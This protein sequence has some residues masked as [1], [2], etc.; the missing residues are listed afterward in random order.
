MKVVSVIDVTTASGTTA[1]QDT[2]VNAQNIAIWNRKQAVLEIEKA[3]K[4]LVWLK[5]FYA[6]FIIISAIFT[7]TVHLSML[8]FSVPNSSVFTK[9]KVRIVSSRVK[10]LPHQGV[11][12]RRNVRES[13]R[14]MK[15]HIQIY[16]P[17][18]PRTY[19]KHLVNLLRSFIP[20]ISMLTILSVD[21]LE[22]MCQTAQWR[23]LKTRLWISQFLKID[24]F[25]HYLVFSH[26]HFLSE[27]LP[28][29]LR[30]KGQLFVNSKWR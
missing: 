1:V 9:N 19:K 8:S 29:S 13:H 3:C 6:A 16:V 11:R 28:L 7:W 12:S 20:D 17:K 25:P 21:T 14:F 30:K 26:E 15:N 23:L 27:M 5:N 22:K 2:K 24:P 10:S 4:R 18:C